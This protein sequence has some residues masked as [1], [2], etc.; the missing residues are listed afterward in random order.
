MKPLVRIVRVSGRPL[1]LRYSDNGKRRRLSSGTHDIAEAERQR[2]EMEAQLRQGLRPVPRR[3]PRPKSAHAQRA[4]GGS[5]AVGEAERTQERL[6][7][8]LELLMAL[9]RNRQRLYVAHEAQALYETTVCLRTVKRDLHLLA[10]VGVVHRTRVFRESR[11]S[12]RRSQG[13]WQTA[14]QWAGFE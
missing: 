5:R 10:R 2:D 6:T 12:R 4:D 8:I 14:Y 3:S 7:R 11:D 13:H 9:Q 1:E